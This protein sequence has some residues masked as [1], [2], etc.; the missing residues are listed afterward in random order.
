MMKAPAHAK[1]LVRASGSD[2]M[3][4]GGRRRR[5]AMRRR[6]E[7]R[8]G[9]EIWCRHIIELVAGLIF[10][11]TDSFGASDFGYSFF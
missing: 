10:R 3:R 1:G 2:V 4:K 6:K 5:S 11:A 7:E 8:F 9:M